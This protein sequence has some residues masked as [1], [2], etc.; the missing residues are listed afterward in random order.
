MLVFPARPWATQGRGPGL[1]HLVISAP[2]MEPR[3]QWFLNKYWLNWT[4]LNFWLTLLHETFCFS[5]AMLRM[6]PRAPQIARQVLCHLSHRP[7]RRHLIVFIDKNISR[8]KV[9]LPSAQFCC[10]LK[11]ALRDSLVFKSGTS[12]LGEDET[13]QDTTAFH[14]NSSAVKFSNFIESTLSLTSY[15]HVYIYTQQTWKVVTEKPDIFIIFKVYEESSNVALQ[16]FLEGDK[17][18]YNEETLSNRAFPGHPP[19]RAA[20]QLGTSSHH[21]GAL[22]PHL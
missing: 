18:E 3:I 12:Y 1:I 7:W 22:V 15:I 5:F 2:N 13:E 9:S 8:G 14:Y 4:E 20:E 16:S 10:E 17:K 6:E 19:S 11:T 21:P